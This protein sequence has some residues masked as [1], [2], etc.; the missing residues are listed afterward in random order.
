M[1]SFPGAV[2]LAL[3]LAAT[4]PAPAGPL[5]TSHLENNDDPSHEWPV[6]VWGSPGIPISPKDIVQKLDAN[7]MWVPT[8]PPE[9]AAYIE[10][11]QKAVSAILSVRG[12]D[13]DTARRA[14]ERLN[15]L[16]ARPSYLALVVH[17]D[18]ADA[19]NGLNY[20]KLANN[21]LETSTDK[22]LELQISVLLF[23]ILYK[24]AHSWTFYAI[25]NFP[26]YTVNAEGL[27]D[28]QSIMIDLSDYVQ[29]LVDLPLP[30]LLSGPL[31]T[32]P[33]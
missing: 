17:R 23:R 22:S 7:E 12:L 4:R 6:C 33:R 3:A 2:I 20:L 18:F 13:R 11:E 30:D 27:N 28:I 21:K 19:R 25:K 10:K 16:E 8:V 32:A 1:K 14:V 5:V 9:E 15:K 31:A 24:A 29:C 26:G